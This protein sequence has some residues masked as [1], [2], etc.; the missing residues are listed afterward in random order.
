MELP[1]RLPKKY[2]N[3]KKLLVDLRTK[4]AAYWMRQGERMALKLFHEMARRVPA[5][6]DFLKKH[7]VQVS[8]VKTIEDFKKY[9]PLIDKDNYLRAYPLEKLCWDGKFK[10]VSWDIAATSG[11]T[12]VPFYFPRT[13]LQNWQYAVMAEL[14]LRNNF[15]IHKKSTLYINCFALG[16]WIGG[17]FTYE[18]LK[19]IAGKGD[20]ALTI[21]NPGLNKV[22]IIKTVRNLGKYFDQVVIGAYPPFLRDVIDDGAQYGLKWKKYNL[23]FVC[24]AEGFS[25]EFRSYIAK[26]SGLKNIYTGMLNHYG[27]V[28][29]GTLAHETPLSIMVRRMAILKPKFFTAVF[30]EG[31]NRL[32]TLAQY[33]PEMFF[34]EE[35]N[36]GLICSSYS[37]LPLVRYDL[38]DHG[39]VHTYEEME[40]RLKK[41]GIDVKKEEEETGISNNCWKL[42]FVYVYERK[43]LSVSLAGATIYPETVK[44]ALHDKKIVKY[45]TGKFTMLVKNDSKLKQYLEIN[46][47]MRSGARGMDKK[48]AELITGVILNKLL[49]ENSEFHSVFHDQRGKDA[50]PKIICW[51]YEHNEYFKP[52][53]KQ[54]WTHKS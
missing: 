20:Y 33:D 39:G 30:R 45:V 31:V 53:G 16:V 49:K 8:K 38:K 23:G 21:I 43:D 50:V 40:R 26:K 47:E 22:E 2:H 36:N 35:Q 11:S 24:S 52:G 19:K 4:P 12:G 7:K 29:Q 51:P 9:V 13:D 18:A 17:I 42:P 10:D 41:S 27:T 54:R 3:P 1:S 15:E 44:K 32:P 6:K 34:F 48:M 46:I 28:D 14:Y 25:E 37:G 5:Y